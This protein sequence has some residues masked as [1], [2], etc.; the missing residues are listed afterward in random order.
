MTIAAPDK[1]MISVAKFLDLF[2]YLKSEGGQQ[3][4]LAIW[5]ISA[6]NACTH[7]LWRIDS[8]R[9]EQI[10]RARRW[11][12]RLGQAESVSVPMFSPF[13]RSDVLLVE[14]LQ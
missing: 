11:V 8:N 14:V 5:T 4:A 1:P 13:T 3:R 7:S 10:C 2:D 9:R 6:E 12:W